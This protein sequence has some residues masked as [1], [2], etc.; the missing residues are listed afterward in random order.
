M[1]YVDKLLAQKHNTTL[2]ELI[3]HY[4]DCCRTNDNNLTDVVSSLDG[5]LN[6]KLFSHLIKQYENSPARTFY[7][8]SFE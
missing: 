1:I 7:P 3:T 8:E 2:T 5:I 6:D 4:Q